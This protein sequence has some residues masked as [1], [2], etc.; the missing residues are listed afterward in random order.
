MIGLFER[1]W[2]GFKKGVKKDVSKQDVRC[3]VKK[4]KKRRRRNKLKR[5]NRK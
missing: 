2:Y 3:A 1:R 5:K 4:K